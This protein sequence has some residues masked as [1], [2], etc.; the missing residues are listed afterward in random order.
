ME[1]QAKTSRFEVLANGGF[2]KAILQ[3]VLITLITWFAG[4]T[5][6]AAQGP[7]GHNDQPVSTVDD[8]LRLT[9]GPIAIGHHGVGPYNPATNPGLPI[10]N[11]VDSVKL[12][13]SLGAR[14]VEVD[15]QLTQDGHRL[16][17]LG[18]RCPI[19]FGSNGKRFAKV[20]QRDLVAEVCQLE[21][22]PEIVV[23]LP[24]A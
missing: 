2:R 4:P 11:T 17:H 7:D 12:A 14:V 3:S 19:R 20:P 18:Y 16:I 15:V 23:H 1:S 6:S 24:T 22:E 21:A 13:Y 10:E 9:V 8:F 5:P